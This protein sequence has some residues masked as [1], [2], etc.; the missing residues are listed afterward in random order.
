MSPLCPYPRVFVIENEGAVEF[1]IPEF[2]GIYD[3][4]PA[5]SYCSWKILNPKGLTLKMN[6]KR[7]T[8]F[9]M[10]LIKNSHMIN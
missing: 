6:M 1:S 4:M 5:N 9:F 3:N 10:I 2:Y 8:V 7:Y